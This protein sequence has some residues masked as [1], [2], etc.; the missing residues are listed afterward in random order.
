MQPIDGLIVKKER[1]TKNNDYGYITSQ[2]D[3]RKAY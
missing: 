3:Y 2:L 1:L